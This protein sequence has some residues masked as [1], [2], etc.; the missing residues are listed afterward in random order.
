MEYGTYVTMATFALAFVA[1]VARATWKVSQIEK[2][3]RLYLD[4]QLDNLHLDQD[5]RERENVERA[6]TIRREFGET[7]N[8]LRTKIHEIETWIRDEFVRTESF[9]AA[10]NRLEKN[11]DKGFDRLEKRLDDVFKLFKN[12]QQNN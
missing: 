7:G 12:M 6:E 3:I 8:A 1:Y 4:A 11:S 5:K 10:I 2:D 9:E